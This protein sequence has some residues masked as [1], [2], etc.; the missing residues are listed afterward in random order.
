[1]LSIIVPT[2]NEAENIGPL[3]SKIFAATKAAAIEAEVIVVDDSSPDGTAKVAEAL[4][5]EFRVSVLRRTG[6]RGLS[7]SVMDGFSRASGDILCVMDADLSHPPEAIPVMFSAIRNGEADF[8]IGSRL[9][10]GGGSTDWPFY[11]KIISIVARTLAR[12][13]TPVKDLTSGYFML[14]KSVIDGVRL[15]PIGFKI[16]L[17]IIAKG[18]YNKVKEVPITFRERV[19]G[20]SKLGARQ[21]LDYL[22]QLSFLYGSRLKKIFRNEDKR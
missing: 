5:P 17:E 4:K 14:K 10:Q 15:D 19:S 2:Y 22:M 18:R 20:R 6:I 1:M 12:P 3:V 7:R 13:I 11:K 8:V 9:V 21:V 16:C